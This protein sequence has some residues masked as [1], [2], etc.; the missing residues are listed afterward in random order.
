MMNWPLVIGVGT[1]VFG[2]LFICRIDN[3][4]LRSLERNGG[5]IDRW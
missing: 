4:Q 3:W 1:I 5:V 2:F